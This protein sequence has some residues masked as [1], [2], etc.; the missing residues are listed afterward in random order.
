M[1]TGKAETASGDTSPSG[2]DVCSEEDYEP[3]S[4]EC[5]EYVSEF[6]STIDYVLVRPI[7]I[8]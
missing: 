1:S 2:S 5:N 3:S 6:L 7:S 8:A 4:R